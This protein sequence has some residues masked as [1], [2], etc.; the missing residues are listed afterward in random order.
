MSPAE[1]KA[2]NDAISQTTPQTKAPALEAYLTAYPQSAVKEA[3]L[4]DLMI[5]YSSF[6]PT[7][8]LDAADR[9]LQ[10]NPNNL[11]A[12]LLEVYFRKT[13]ADQQT[14][15]ATK[16]ASLDKAAEFA[17][18]GLA[19]TKPAEM[20]DD[21]FT[22]VKAS[23]YPVFYSAIATA[24]LNK[25]DTATAIT[26]Y[27]QELASVPVADT[28]KPGPLLQD[29]YFLGLAYL[30]STPPDLVNCTWYI[31]RFVAFAPEP[32]KSQMLPTAK[33]CYKKYHGADDGYEAVTAAVQTSLDPPAG[34]ALKPAP[35][36]SDIVAQVI[37]NTPDLGTLAVSDKEFILQNGKPADAAKVWDTIKGKSVQ[38]PDVT[39]VSATESAIQASV[40]EDAVLSKV[41]DFTFNMKEPLKTVPAPGTKVTLSGTYASYTVGGVAGA[42]A[43]AA[44]AATT[45]APAATTPDAAAPAATPAPAAAPAPA[46]AAGPAGPV[47][48]AMS[49]SAVVDKKAPA[50]KP[51]ATHRAAPRKR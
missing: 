16:Q 14:D 18:K 30:Q 43:T 50:K 15:P 6:D 34:F 45:P 44:P 12:L 26:N 8:T 46:P 32:Y 41:A 33:Y 21:D 24:A 9:L 29:T 2:Y 13:A 39:V 10:V 35:S 3:T 48:I 22:K 49:D 20:S 17:Q 11:R 40:S 27:K 31:S 4:Q 25:K 28:T 37:A 42:G 38:L 23:A 7:K 19:A 51:T 47:V 5:S 36:P 1:Y